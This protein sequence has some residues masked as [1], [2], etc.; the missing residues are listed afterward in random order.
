LQRK[1]RSG[2]ISVLVSY[3]ADRCGDVVSCSSIGSNTSSSCTTSSNSSENL[4]K[5]HQSHIHQ[6]RHHRGRCDRHHEAAITSFDIPVAE[7]TPFL[8]SPSC[9]LRKA[10]GVCYT[11]F[12]NVSSELDRAMIDYLERSVGLSS[13]KKQ[14][15]SKNAAGKEQQG[16]VLC[17]TN[18]FLRKHIKIESRRIA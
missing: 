2:D 18:S 1:N 4:Q 11:S 7:T 8:R 15:S 5:Q 12:G 17:T 9:T 3:F 10:L 6:Q 16:F 14:K 13:G